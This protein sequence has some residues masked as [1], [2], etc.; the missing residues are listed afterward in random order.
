MIQIDQINEKFKGV[1]EV[2]VGSF[3]IVG[4]NP[5]SI[6]SFLNKFCE[7]DGKQSLAIG[8]KKIRIIH[9]QSYQSFNDVENKNITLI[10]NAKSNN[11][12]EIAA[13]WLGHISWYLS[14]N[15]I[16][17]TL[18]K[19]YRGTYFES[20]NNIISYKTKNI[21][22]S[23]ELKNDIECTNDLLAAVCAA[24]EAGISSAAIRAVLSK[25]NF[26]NQH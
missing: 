14:S 21:L 7:Y 22:E 26:Y 20:N 3:S 18:N 2:S 12:Y 6:L 25:P 24:H 16:D 10:L 15:L 19:N 1:H 13:N 4:F 8:V 17:D 5:I 11:H 9:S 23:Y